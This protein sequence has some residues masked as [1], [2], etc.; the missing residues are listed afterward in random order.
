MITEESYIKRNNEVFASEKL[1]FI[2]VLVQSVA[3]KEYFGVNHLVNKTIDLSTFEDGIYFVRF[4]LSGAYK[5][6]ATIVI[7]Q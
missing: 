2:N 6:K 3:I 4:Y 1:E 5:G 7:D